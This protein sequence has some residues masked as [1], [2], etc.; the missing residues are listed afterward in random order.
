[1]S[2]KKHLLL[3]IVASLS[4]TLSS[5]NNEKKQ[6]LN[7]AQGYLDATG[8]YRI[9][10][11]YPYATRNTRETTLTFL[12]ENIIPLLDSNYIKSNTP[13]TINIDSA[14]ILNDTAWIFYTKTTPIKKLNNQIYLIKEDGK[15]LVDIPIAIPNNLPLGKRDSTT[16]TMEHVLKRINSDST[17]QIVKF[18]IPTHNTEN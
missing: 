14:F 16:D 2:P 8:N 11:A 4:I 10:E 5:C 3:L 17:E 1:M 15:W 18:R 12:T 13:A 7:T 9:E 6:I